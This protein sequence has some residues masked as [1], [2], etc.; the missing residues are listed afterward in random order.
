[1]KKTALS[2]G[3]AA[4]FIMGGSSATAGSI[5]NSDITTFTP[6]TTAKAS[7]V[8]GNFDAVKTAVNDNDG[9]ITAN[10][11]AIGDTSSGLVKD[12]ADNK[13]AIEAIDTSG[14]GA[15]TM[16]IGDAN[17]GLVKDIADNK[18]AI[19]AVDTSGIAT[20]AAAIGDANSGLVKDVADNKTA[21]DLK[22][23]KPAS[24]RTID[25]NSTDIAALE[26]TVDGSNTTDG[27]VKRVEDL[28]A[29][30][31]CPSDMAAVGSICFDKTEYM[32]GGVVKVQV[33]QR[34]ALKLCAVAGKRLPSDA[35]WSMAAENDGGALGI[36]NMA[37]GVYEW[38]ADWTGDDRGLLR[39]NGNRAVADDIDAYIMWK[40]AGN[41]GSDLGGP[42]TVIGFRCAK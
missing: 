33:T 21:I 28:E 40:F 14:I 36:I 20:N 13:A 12:V 11:A 4:A 6:E 18:A 3:I 26:L 24:G 37:G 34:E 42:N 41:G 5:S 15:N 16:A 17:S 35:E 25:D 29:G 22:A 27:L 39:G 32:E 1:M 23:D 10:V 31:G 7:E 19:E 9:R 2:I 38:V 8:N 30:G